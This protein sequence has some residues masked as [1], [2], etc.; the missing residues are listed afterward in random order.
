[1]KQCH[2]LLIHLLPIKVQQKQRNAGKSALLCICRKWMTCYG[3]NKNEKV[4]EI[5]KR[6]VQTC[7]NDIINIIQDLIKETT[8]NIG[9]VG[10]VSTMHEILNEINAANTNHEEKIMAIQDIL[11]Q[12]KKKN[13]HSFFTAAYKKTVQTLQVE[14]NQEN[15]SNNKF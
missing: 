8:G 15:I 9:H 5:A 2:L 13:H 4:R 7:P 6:I 1:M 12:A 11:E 14:D 3:R 10:S